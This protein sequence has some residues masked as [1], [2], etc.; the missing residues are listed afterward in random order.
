[1]QDSADSLVMTSD[2]SPWSAWHFPRPSG[3]LVLLVLV[4]KI[5]RLHVR[6][7]RSHGFR[8]YR[9]EVCVSPEKS[10]FKFLCDAEH[11]LH[12]KHLPIAIRTCAYTYRWNLYRGRNVLCECCRNFFQDNSKATTLGQQLCI[13]KQLFRFCLFFRANCLGSEFVN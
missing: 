9:I 13:V 3:I 1:M 10:R 2:E 7:V 6:N 4:W 8:N 12:D 5:F 11:V